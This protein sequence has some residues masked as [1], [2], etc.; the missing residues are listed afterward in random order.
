M[1]QLSDVSA[2]IDNTPNAETTI[3]NHSIHAPF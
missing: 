2:S 1:S 3:H